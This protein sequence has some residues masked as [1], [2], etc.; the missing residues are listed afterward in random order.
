LQRIEKFDG[1][2]LF[3]TNLSQNIDDAFKRRFDAHIYYKA[4]DIDHLGEFFDHNWPE[5]LTLNSGVN[6]KTLLIENHMSPAALLKVI[7]RAA[8]LT[9]GNNES[10]VSADLL[11]KCFMDEAFLYRGQAAVGR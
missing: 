11:R 7:A 8:M 5:A 1:I 2:V 9:I 4:L 6:V 10:V 3:A